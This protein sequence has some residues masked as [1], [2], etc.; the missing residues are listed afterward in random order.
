MLVRCACAPRKLVIPRRKE[1]PVTVGEFGGSGF[2]IPQSSNKSASVVEATWY[3]R[4]SVSTPVLS[5][6]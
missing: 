2:W 5:R 3:H 4:D 6:K 1:K